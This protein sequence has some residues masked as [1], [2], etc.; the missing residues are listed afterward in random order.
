MLALALAVA[1]EDGLPA[2]VAL[3]LRFPEIAGAQETGWQELVA[4]HLGLADWERVPIG[5]ELDFLGEI[6]TGAL[7]RDGLLWPANAHAHAPLLARV[8]GGCLITGLDGDGLFGWRFARV[9]A[10]LT[11]PGVLGPRALARAALAVAPAGVRSA[12]HRRAHRPDLP[13]LTVAGQRRV[14]ALLADDAAR[15]PVRWDRR[16]EWFAGRRHLSV[17]LWSV[18][19]FGH[20]HD[21]RVVHPLQDRAFLAAL[22]R[23]GGRGGLGPRDR[24]M[25]RLFDDLLPA[26][27]LQRRSK[28]EFGRAF[29]GERAR[30]FAV[31]WD[32]TG[33]DEE[34]I[35]PGRLRAVWTAGENPPLAAAT[36]LQDA[37]LS[38][39]APAP[40]TA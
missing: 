27:I 35:D 31:S 24:A 2:P 18:G 8:P 39:A 19:R 23:A 20:P 28:A 6:A 40:T 37:W 16:V 30:R 12:R 1:R 21:T 9:R 7:R 33:L 17:G 10:D 32:G 36:L 13:W 38:A 3:T 29:W 14:G 34:L 15:E 22:A 25:R 11:R 4:A 26:A 5:A